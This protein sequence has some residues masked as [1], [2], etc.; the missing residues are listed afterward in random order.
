M[1]KNPIEAEGPY[2]M[3]RL[4]GFEVVDWAQDY[5]RVT[6]DLRADHG[7]RFGLPHGGLYAVLMDTAMGY[8][9]VYTGDP[10][11]PRYCMTLSMTVNFLSQPKGT[12]LRVEGRRV[13]GG[14]STFFAEAD[15]VDDTGER[16]AT[17][18]GVFRYRKS[19][20]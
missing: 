8:A 19:R 5:A 13:G 18:T 14:R 9:G 12:M 4:I 7:N 20:A 6:L 11:A 3:Q 16:L 1:T 17:A 2:P 15:V 10:D